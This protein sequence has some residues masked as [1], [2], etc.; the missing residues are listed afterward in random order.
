MAT[1]YLVGIRDLVAWA[2]FRP[3]LSYGEYRLALLLTEEEQ[4][5]LQKAM[6][7]PLQEM[8]RKIYDF[9][10]LNLAVGGNVHWGGITL[11]ESLNKLLPYL[12]FLPWYP[13]IVFPVIARIRAA[14]DTYPIETGTEKDIKL[15]Q[16]PFFTCSGT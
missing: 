5:I 10:L 16:G 2:A 1:K 13:Q 9:V 3:D 11:D 8:Q 7:F 15:D 12:T 4:Q 6:D 14:W